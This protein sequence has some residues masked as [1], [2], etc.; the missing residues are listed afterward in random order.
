MK[1]KF[2]FVVMLKKTQTQD[3]LQ[4]FS[5]MVWAGMAVVAGLLQPLGLWSMKVWFSKSRELGGGAFLRLSSRLGCSRP[6][7]CVRGAC[8]ALQLGPVV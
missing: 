1:N 6:H 4:V 2:V 3:E 5:L 8:S 7:H